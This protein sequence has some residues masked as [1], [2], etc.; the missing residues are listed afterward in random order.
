MNRHCPLDRGGATAE[1]VH[2]AGK[3]EGE[4]EEGAKEEEAREEGAKEEGTREEL[5]HQGAQDDF[6]HLWATI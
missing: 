4:K 5:H 3:E 6:A 1:S 2:P